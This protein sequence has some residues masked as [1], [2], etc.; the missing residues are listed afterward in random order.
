VLSRWRR[1]AGRAPGAAALA[2][3]AGAQ[4]A[5]NEMHRV[6]CKTLTRLRAQAR[7]GKQLTTVGHGGP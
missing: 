6:H 5:V 1:G 7:E 4:V 3:G 2:S